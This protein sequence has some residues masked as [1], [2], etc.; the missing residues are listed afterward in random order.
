MGPHRHFRR[1][2]II[3]LRVLHVPDETGRG[4][5]VVKDLGVL[6]GIAFNRPHNQDFGSETGH[7]N[8]GDRFSLFHL[9][10]RKPEILGERIEILMGRIANEPILAID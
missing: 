8:Q 4:S 7:G 5:P 6:Y 2:T 9:W 1:G 3:F 10:V